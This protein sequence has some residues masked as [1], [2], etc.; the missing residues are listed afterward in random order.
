MDENQ[1]IKVI[2]LRPFGVK[3][4]D[5]DIDFNQKDRPELV[6]QILQCCIQTDDEKMQDKAFFSDLTVGKRTE[7]LIIIAFSEN[8]SDLIVHLSCLNNSCHNQMEVGISV[9]FLKELQHRADHTGIFGVRIGD[10]TISIRKPKGSDQCE[11]VRRSFADQDDA[12]KAMIMTLI[13]DN[14]GTCNLRQLFPGDLIKTIENAMEDFDPLVNFSLLARCPYCQNEGNYDIDLQRLS[15]QKL[16]E[17]QLQMLRDVHRLASKYH[18]NEQEILN[19]PFW[20][21]SYYISLI[22][23]EENQ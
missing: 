3:P 15:L 13:S 23:D 6:T 21:R 4:K 2:S 16:H 5:L 14:E 8:S 22:E 20:R 18:W 7:Y 11:W 12:K 17:S 19:L 9:E 1:S 10:E